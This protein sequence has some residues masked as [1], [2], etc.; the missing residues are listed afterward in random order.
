MLDLNSGAALNQFVASAGKA[1]SNTELHSIITQATEHP[2]VFVFGE[3]L[4]LPN[5]RQLNN[6]EEDKKFFRLLE[7]F[8]F[9]TW[10]NYQQS[11][12]LYPTLNEDQKEKLRLLT[13]V[14]EARDEKNLS[15]DS[16]L[17]K[18][19]LENVREFENLAIKGVY[20]G[21]FHIKMNQLSGVLHIT[22][23]FCRDVHEKDLKPLLEKVNSWGKQT[24]EVLSLLQERI[25]F[26]RNQRENNLRE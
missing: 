20:K 9:G 16:L 21:L 19:G 14:T 8:A 3:L 26:A 11:P 2:D 5:V 4:A 13:I 24:I 10:D 25:E 6:Q 1:D 18:I 7:L 12:A 15:Y 17:P 22:G 23:C